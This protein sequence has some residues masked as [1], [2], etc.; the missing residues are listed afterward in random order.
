M[1]RAL[2]KDDFQQLRVLYKQIQ[3]IH[4][5]NRPDVYKDINPLTHEYFQFLLSDKNT[6]ATVYE[7]DSKL[8]GFCVVTIKEIKDH[9]VMQDRKT[10]FM[11]GLCVQ[12]NY[13][14][15]GIGKQLFEDIKGRLKEKDISKLELMVWNF[16]E[17]AINFYKNKGMKIRSEIMEL[18]L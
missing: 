1:I 15:Q 7:E 6:L 2:K 11:E 9:P 12:E 3:D 8:I 4:V 13:R 18:S 14:C 5:K 17:S 16:N 10:A